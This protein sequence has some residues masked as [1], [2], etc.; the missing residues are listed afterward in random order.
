MLV[1]IYYKFGLLNAHVLIMFVYIYMNVKKFCLNQTMLM[2]AG[3]II[4]TPCKLTSCVDGRLS[5]H[6]QLGSSTSRPV[7]KQHNQVKTSPQTARPGQDQSSNSTTRSRPVIK[8][9]D[10][11]K[12]SPQTA[13]PGQDQSSNSTIRSR[14]VLKQHDQVKTSPQTARSG[15]HQSS[16]STTMSRPVLQQH[17]QVKTNPQTARPVTSR[18]V[19]NDLFLL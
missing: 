2:N 8:Q 1:S 10:K 9:H 15:Q 19:R 13:R 4:I 7:L 16:N 3:V 17:D 5:G 14:P 12:T 6:S 18:L 11:V